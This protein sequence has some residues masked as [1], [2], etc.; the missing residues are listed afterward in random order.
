MS[1]SSLVLFCLGVSCSLWLGVELGAGCESRSEEVEKSE[2][3]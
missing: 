1:E 3:L 2:S